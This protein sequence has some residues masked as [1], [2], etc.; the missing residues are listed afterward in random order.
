MVLFV[1]KVLLFV[2]S[3]VHY[4]KKRG[5]DAGV[6]IDLDTRLEFFLRRLGLW[7]RSL[8]Q[9]FHSHRNRLSSLCS[10]AKNAYLSY[11]SYHFK[12]FSRYPYCLA[13]FALGMYET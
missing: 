4:K 8:P 9:F 12:V 3:E 10:P 11:F 5:A 13:F 1:R 6:G 2:T 7:P